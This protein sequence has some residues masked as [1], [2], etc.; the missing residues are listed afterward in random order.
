M[1]LVYMVSGVDIVLE[2]LRLFMNNL[3]YLF[4]LYGGWVFLYIVHV[5]PFAAYIILKASITRNA[6]HLM[7]SS[8][9]HKWKVVKNWEYERKRTFKYKR[10]NK[11]F[12]KAVFVVESLRWLVGCW[13]GLLILGGVRGVGDWVILG[14]SLEEGFSGFW[15][16]Y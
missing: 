3:L 14:C 9:T 4:E 12:Q 16:L 15:S 6:F 2:K 7:Y 5:F 8:A 10:R 13:F 11:K 1:L